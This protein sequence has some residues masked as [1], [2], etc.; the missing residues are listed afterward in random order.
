M[1]AVKLSIFIT[2]VVVMM[3]VAM[4]TAAA[5][6]FLRVDLIM[7]IMM[8]EVPLRYPAVLSPWQHTTCLTDTHKMMIINAR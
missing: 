2:V 6:I 4:A 7:F 3:P 1:N 8:V 5:V